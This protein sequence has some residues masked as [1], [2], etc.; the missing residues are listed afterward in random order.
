MNG[1]ELPLREPHQSRTKLDGDAMAEQFELARKAYEADQ[2]ELARA[3]Y[4][5]MQPGFGDYANQSARSVAQGALDTTSS[6]ARFLPTLTEGVGGL[7]GADPAR[8]EGAAKLWPGYW[9]GR[10]L[11]AIR[12]EDDPEVAAG[13]PGV[14]KWFSTTGARAVG[15]AL[16]YIATA[17]AGSAV[18][19]SA[20]GATALTAA[21]GM[22]SNAVAGY[23]EARLSGASPEAAM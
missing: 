13:A 14:A 3:Q 8:I 18:G 5:A 15:S 4:E 10:G 16:P 22:G 17:G 7:V 1:D 2:F 20:R 21:M 19:L 12:P 11:E 23:E 9:I 6:V